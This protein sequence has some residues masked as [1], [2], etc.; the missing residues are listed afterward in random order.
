VSTSNTKPE[1]DVQVRESGTWPYHFHFWLN[2][3]WQARKPI[4]AKCFISRRRG[5]APPASHQHELR[6]STSYH[7]TWTVCSC[8]IR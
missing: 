2:W 1:R 4:M 8:I 7:S 6:R 5:R 3:G